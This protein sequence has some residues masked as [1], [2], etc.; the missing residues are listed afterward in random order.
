MG[1]F[2]S[3]RAD[4]GS[5]SDTDSENE[6]P[7][8]GG[9]VAES[10]LFKK[11][12]Q[13]NDDSQQEE[14]HPYD[15]MAPVSSLFFISQDQERSDNIAKQFPH[16]MT[17]PSTPD[18]RELVS[19]GEDAELDKQE[20]DN[21]SPLS[22]LSPSPS[23]PTPTPTPSTSSM[24]GAP[25][26]RLAKVRTLSRSVVRP[27][28]PT[29][30]KW[31]KLSNLDRV[32]NPTFSS[33]IHYFENAV[34]EDRTFMDVVSSLK[35]SLAKTL[36]EFY[37]LAGRLTLRENGVVDVFCDDQ[38][39]ILFEAVVDAELKDWGG[40]AT[41]YA[42]AGLEVAKVGQGPT[43]VPDQLNPMPV[44]IIQVTRFRCG[45]IAIG[46]NWHHTVADGFSGTHFMRSWA[47][48]A[49]GKP[50]SL[51][52]NHDREVLKPR[53]PLDPSL[54]YGYSTKHLEGEVAEAGTSAPTELVTFP[55]KKER[56][57]ELK[58]KAMQVPPANTPRPYTSAESVSGHLWIQMTK[59]RAA[60]NGYT[61]DTAKDSI[62]KFFMFVDGRKR[63]KLPAGYFGNVVCSACAVA[64]ES[65]ILNG[66]V[67]YAAS[68]IR[69]ATRN[70]TA[71]Y[72]RS[73]IDWVEDKGMSSGKSDHIN[74]LGHDVAATFWT[75][76]P[77]YDIEFG[78]GRP[79]FAARNSPPRPLIDGIAMMPSASGDGDMVALL[80][81]HS[82][83]T[84]FSISRSFFS[85]AAGKILLSGIGN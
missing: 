29:E 33:V 1:Q 52:P 32:V 54:V 61:A 60:A 31:L 5:D 63:L 68:L 34:T 37:P 14:D 72:F 17:A 3:K 7:V 67:G 46:T 77:L 30:Q 23:P 10:S 47:E 70:I 24:T 11:R 27:E 65:D 49:L 19:I 21:K 2:L 42:L 71:D 38:G 36:V 40:P 76:F 83:R 82:D 58:K 12:T 6:V 15:K 78:W 9:E 85:R 18:Q 8:T 48:I 53:D 50:L 73:L 44:T 80:N 22:L 75:F 45:T 79:V 66:H 62:T 69:T 13:H 39:T 20:A 84:Q 64:K 56:I 51:K 81:L 55:L 25:S 57:L 35:A 43:Y 74:S 26:P 28:T 16:F 4:G 41:N 59:A